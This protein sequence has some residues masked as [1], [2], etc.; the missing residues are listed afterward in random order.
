[1]ASNT[2]NLGLLKKDPIA[3]GNETFNIQTMLNDNWDKIDEAVGNI[4]VPDAS[5]TDKGVVQLSNATNGTREDVA[6]TEKAVKA[7]YNQAVSYIEAR[8]WQKSPLTTNDGRGINLP[9]GTDL[10]TVVNIGFYDVNAPL[11]APSSIMPVG[12]WWYLRVE[13]HRFDTPDNRWVTQRITHFY[14]GL[15]FIRQSRTLS[16]NVVA[17]TRWEPVLNGF[18]YKPNLVSNSTGL[19]GFARWTKVNGE[20]GW[21]Y[22][23][24]AGNR[25]SSFF[26]DAEP[27]GVNYRYIE[28]ES[29]PVWSNVYYTLS[30]DFLNPTNTASEIYAEVL[31]NG[32]IIGQ[33]FC[34]ASTEWHRKS[35]TFNTG[36]ARGVTIRLVVKSDLPKASRGFS[37][38]M[39]NEG[40]TE[41]VWN[42]DADGSLLFQY[43]NDGK[44]RIASAINGKGVP[45]SGSDD[46]ATLAT[47]IMQI[48][49]GM[50]LYSGVIP[51][52]I[53]DSGKGSVKGG[54]IRG[55]PFTPKIIII[56]RSN[57]SSY[58]YDCVTIA[59]RGLTELRNGTAWY[60]NPQGALESVYLKSEADFLPDG[61]AYWATSA[62]AQPGERIRYYT[63]I[64]YLVLG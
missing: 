10:N 32:S 61:F 28:S 25:I 19:L 12:N 35:Y 60:E 55:I 11:N 24:E 63:D 14:T 57:S 37:R 1:M 6:A 45:A 50:K 62:A 23:R 15:E 34:D 58:S 20:T 47:K 16:L 21:N 56:S 43:A 4:K 40:T 33:V 26:F 36:S 41:A 22:Y 46:F 30:L 18:S 49:L 8:G 48:P 5:L 31:G 52:F 38:I 13:R 29:I 27:S 42:D 44:S 39:L 54:E 3:D 64:K 53:V 17:W 9:D 51:D 7:A 59:F 2:P